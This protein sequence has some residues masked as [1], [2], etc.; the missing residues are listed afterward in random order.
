MVCR[1][2]LAPGPSVAASSR[3]GGARLARRRPRSI[4]PARNSLTPA[5]AASISMDSHSTH[6]GVA[7]FS[8]NE[9]QS[10]RAS[11]RVTAGPTPQPWYRR[12]KMLGSG[13]SFWLVG[14]VRCSSRCL[15]AASN[16][17]ESPATSPARSPGVFTRCSHDAVLKKARMHVAVHRSAI[18]AAEWSTSH[19][20]ADCAPSSPPGTAQ[21]TYAFEMSR[22]MLRSVEPSP[23]ASLH[24]RSDKRTES[25]APGARSAAAR[26]AA[27]RSSD[28]SAP[29]AVSA[30]ASGPPP[31]GSGPRQPFPGALSLV[32]SRSMSGS[33]PAWRSGTPRR[34]AASR[35]GRASAGMPRELQSSRA[36]GS[37]RAGAVVPVSA[38]HWLVLRSS[39]ASRSRRRLALAS[40]VSK[41][42]RSCS[43]V[44]TPTQRDLAYLA[45]ASGASLSPAHSS[46]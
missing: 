10:K 44:A 39:R 31:R 35:L 27:G 3:I 15:S 17:D 46:S 23:L 22:H 21:G 7:A 41:A 8:T 33:A 32:S 2:T 12:L 29:S 20:A 19:A 16:S 5:P 4:L 9:P 18:G 26:R 38:R 25:T 1:L 14:A 37:T 34:S 30:V 6:V 36:P 11:A 42:L 13:P 45:A 40:R 43:C 24:E 28:T